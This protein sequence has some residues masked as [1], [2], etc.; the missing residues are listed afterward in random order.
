MRRG[1]PGGCAG[2]GGG[3][4]SPEKTQKLCAPWMRAGGQRGQAEVVPWVWAGPGPCQDRPTVGLSKLSVPTPYAL[5]SRTLPRR[6][7]RHL[8]V[9]WPTFENMSP[10][11]SQKPVGNLEMQQQFLL[12]GEFFIC[13]TLMLLPLLQT[14]D[15]FPAG[16]TFFP[17]P[18]VLTLPDAASLWCGGEQVGS[19]GISD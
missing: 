2:P 16:H 19:R 18:G 17:Q 8:D 10:F 11:F 4:V 15:P 6:L 14:W 5:S 9:A 3:G 13:Q 7:P 12:L 1:A